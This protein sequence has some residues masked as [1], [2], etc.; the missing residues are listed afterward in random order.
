MG[1]PIDVGQRVRVNGVEGVVSK[2][3]DGQL[4]GMVEVRLERGTICVDLSTLVNLYPL[5]KFCWQ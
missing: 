3:C 4:K 5:K 2:V 1:T